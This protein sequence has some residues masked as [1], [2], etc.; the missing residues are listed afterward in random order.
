MKIPCQKLVFLHIDLWNPI[1]WKNP[2]GV[3][4]I[5]KLEDNIQQCMCIDFLAFIYD[6]LVLKLLKLLQSVSPESCQIEPRV[7]S[8]V[9]ISKL[10]NNA[11]Q[12]AAIR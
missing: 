6:K 9:H 5:L 2:C 11:M 10:D 12:M 8:G 4:K 1:S 3:H 7:V